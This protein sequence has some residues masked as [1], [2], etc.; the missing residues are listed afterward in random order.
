[1]SNDEEFLSFVY[2][3][4]APVEFRLYYNADGN[5]ICYTCEQLE[6][7]YIIVDAQ[8]YAEARQDVQVVDGKVTRIVPKVMISKLKP[9][10]TGTITLKEDISIVCEEESDNTQKWNLVSHELQ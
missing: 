2:T 7:D 1:M 8:T 3:P 4:P 10:S 6:G 9:S 5:V